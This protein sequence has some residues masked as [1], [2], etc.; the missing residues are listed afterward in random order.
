MLAE[1]GYAA[2]EVSSAIAR[3][4]GGGKLVSLTFNVT[5][6]PKLVIRDVA[7]IGNR[8]VPDG[9]LVK[10]LKSNRPQG[11]LS[12]VSSRGAYNETTYAD[13]A[14]RVEDYYR[15]LGAEADGIP[16]F[17]VLFGNS[18]TEALTRIAELTGGQVFDA[19]NGDLAGAFQ[20]IRGY[21]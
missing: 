20:E 5:R 10:V 21:Q 6:G 16:T 12:L 1:K 17:V 14:Q 19:L 13:D 8:V 7:F 18:D 11:L 3:I 2:A 9:D 15:D 4:D